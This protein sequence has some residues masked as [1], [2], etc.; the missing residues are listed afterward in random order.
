[1][2]KVPRDQWKTAFEEHGRVPRLESNDPHTILMPYIPNINAYD[3]IANNHA[4]KDF[5]E[6][7]WATDL[8]AEKKE[9]LLQSIMREVGDIHGQGVA[10]GE[11]I[12][13]NLILTKDKRAIM[14]DPEIRY[15]KDVPLNE[16][17]ARDLRDLILSVC[18]AMRK[19]EG[20]TDFASTVKV[21]LDEY[22]DDEVVDILKKISD[23][24]FSLGLQLTF[25]NEK[26]RTGV[27]S[28]EEYQAILS[29]VREYE[30]ET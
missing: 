23:G 28:K 20:K 19:S 14:C 17:Q 9:E 29:A 5:G 16:A 7:D 15:D 12:L 27:E 30:R 4:I 11:M 6:I 21:L 2:G 13:Q 3:A 8:T 22:H 1:M 10:W 25:W 26:L 18:A 24:Q